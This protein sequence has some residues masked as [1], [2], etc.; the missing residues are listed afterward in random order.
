MSWPVSLWP[1]T[2]GS[3]D[4]KSLEVLIAV[5]APHTAA[6]ALADCAFYYGEV[7]FMGDGA[8]VFAGDFRDLPTFVRSER[9][10]ELTPNNIWPGD[11]SWLI[12]TDYDLNA[13]RVS[14]STELIEALSKHQDLDTIRC[15]RP[16]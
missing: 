2:E 15:E 5:V 12:Y 8:T 9:S 6:Q 4:A 13:T 10:H 1:P 3:L 11:R 14:G 16:M 7:A